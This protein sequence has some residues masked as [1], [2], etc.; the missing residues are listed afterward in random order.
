MSATKSRIGPTDLLSMTNI[1]SRSDS[2]IPSSAVHES[3]ESTGTAEL[4]PEEVSSSGV[5]E[6]VVSAPIAEAR[7][8]VEKTPT[9]GHVFSCGLLIVVGMAFWVRS[10]FM[11]NE[12]NNLKL[13]LV[14]SDSL[15][16]STV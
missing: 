14:D 16:V 3:S 2:V 9:L 10:A 8:P 15:S 13:E 7:V 6:G 1:L 12:L 4:V 5:I 11:A